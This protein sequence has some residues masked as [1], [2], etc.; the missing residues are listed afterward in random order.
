MSDIKPPRIF[1]GFLTL[2]GVAM[3]LGGFSILSMGGGFYFVA[4]GVGVAISGVLIALGKK[5]GA[6]SYGLTLVML[7]IWSFIEVGANVPEL[8]P[9]IA[10][11]A[12]I[13]AYIFSIKIQSRLA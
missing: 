5:V 1:G 4:V 9:R 6:Y 2:L 12:L 10:V 11:P 13:A 7:V 8:L 3:I